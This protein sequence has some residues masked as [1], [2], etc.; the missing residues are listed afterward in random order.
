MHEISYHDFPITMKKS[1]IHEILDLECESSSD[2]GTSLP[3]PIT[4][5]DEVYDN[6]EEARAEIE[7]RT[8]GDWYAQM[9]VMY[10][11]VDYKGYSD[12]V[13]ALTDKYNEALK[14]Y[15]DANNTIH[16]ATTTTEY[17]G[18]KSCGAR[19]KRELMIKR[20]AANL[21][22]MFGADMRPESTIKRLEAYKAKTDDCLSK[23]I[24]RKKFEE[25]KMPTKIN[26]MVKTEWH[27]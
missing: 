7:R 24:E 21:C 22:A 13:A 4:W 27:V 9:A 19:F 17:V 14:K 6:A 26:W 12:K 3:N 16:Y 11:A 25:S 10:K 2:S 15:Q 18:C 20:P 5:I 1:E 8:E 23:V